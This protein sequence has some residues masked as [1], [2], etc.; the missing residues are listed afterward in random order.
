MVMKVMKAKVKLIIVKND[1]TNVKML[2]R[3]PAGSARIE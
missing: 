1:F 3:G 2:P